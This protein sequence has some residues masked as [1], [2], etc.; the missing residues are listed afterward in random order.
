MKNL[1]III[2]LLFTINSKA[3]VST[4]CL[5]S[6][7]VETISVYNENGIVRLSL[8]DKEVELYI[9]LDGVNTL[10]KSTT[11]KYILEGKPALLYNIDTENYNILFDLKS[12]NNSPIAALLDISTNCIIFYYSDGSS[13]L[14]IGEGVRILL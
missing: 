11:A 14:Y 10:Y 1:I 7:D 12:N 13:L 9:D 4:I 8:L 5:D 2:C 6:N 3:Q